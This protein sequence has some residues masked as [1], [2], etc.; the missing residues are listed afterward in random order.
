MTD[1]TEATPA[2]ASAA[3]TTPAAAP[4]IVPPAIIVSMPR[5]GPR[6]TDT[7][8]PAIRPVATAP[9]QRPYAVGDTPRIVMSAKDEPVMNANWPLNIS[10]AALL[11]GARAGV[12]VGLGHDAPCREQEGGA[13]GA[14]HEE[15]G[16]PSRE[17]VHPAA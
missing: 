16:P 6:R 7:R 11:G 13:E 17:H 1:A 12:D 10:A 2:H 3:I 9:K 8:L 15:D 14:E 5:R 4:I